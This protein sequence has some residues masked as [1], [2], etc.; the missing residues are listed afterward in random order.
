MSRA[1]LLLRPYLSE[2][3]SVYAVSALVNNPANEGPR[4]VEPLSRFYKRGD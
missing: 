4:C 3:M 2:E 1:E